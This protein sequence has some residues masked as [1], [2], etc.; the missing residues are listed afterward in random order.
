MGVTAPLLK[1]LGPLVAVELPRP[2]DEM[3]LTIAIGTVESDTQVHDI[4]PPADAAVLEVNTGLEWD[5]DLLERDPYGE[6]WMMKIKVHKPDQLRDLMTPGAYR[7]Y[8]EDLWG[9]EMD[10]EE[11]D[12]EQ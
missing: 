10:L 6:G 9:D 3:K 8:C 7:A 12:S 1:W 5:L 2:D 11:A 4:M